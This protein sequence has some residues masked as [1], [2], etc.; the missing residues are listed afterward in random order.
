MRTFLGA[1]LF[2]A[3]LAGCKTLSTVPVPWGKGDSSPGS[4]TS[5]NTGSDADSKSGAD[6]SSNSGGKSAK[7]TGSSTASS[8]GKK[9]SSPS[10]EASKRAGID[11]LIAQVS[12]LSEQGK[13]GEASEQLKIAQQLAPDD[14]KVK[15][16]ATQLAALFARR[17]DTMVSQGSL[18]EAQ[19]DFHKAVELDRDDVHAK[20][21]AKRLAQAFADRAVKS[22]DEGKPSEAQIAVT[23]ALE[24]DTENVTANRLAKR[25]AQDFALRSANLLN[26]GNE[27]EARTNLDAARKLDA[28][29]ELANTLYGSITADPAHELGAKFFRYTVK[30]RDTLSKIAEQYL[31]DQYKF[32]LLARYNGIAVPRTLQAQQVIKVPGKQAIDS[33]AVTKTPKAVVEKVPV[34][35]SRAKAAYEECK[36]LA[37]AGDNDRAYERCREAAALS[38]RAPA[39]QADAQHLRA[40]LIPSYDRKAR[41][42]Y[43][44]QDLD[45][46]IR[47]WDR[48]MQLDPTNEPAERERDRCVRLR[49][50]INSVGPK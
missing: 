33:V 6:G 32:Y 50:T 49:D 28:K 48:V 22:R 11:E 15:T 41:E 27:A 9:D 37:N 3:I 2:V 18:S 40:E 21:V 45:G 19:T 38:P 14:P 31:N 20:S 24:I 8:S 29:N 17:A 5:S 43:R 42:A 10:V 25:I 47:S 7:S 13:L 4:G 46:C 26:D 23:S 44:R 1:L 35:E 12:G 30:P 36:R 39:Y 34:D 16:A